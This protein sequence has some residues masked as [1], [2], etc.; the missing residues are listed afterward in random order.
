MT[1]LLPLFLLILTLYTAQK[2]NSQT[3]TVL[4][5]NIRYDNPKD[6]SNRWIF[7]RESAVNLINHYSPQVFGIQ[8]GLYNQN[9]YLKNSLKTYS[10]VGVGREDGK[11]KGEYAA[12][13]YDS[14]KFKLLKS[15]VFWLS[16][17]PDTVSIGWDA[18]L[19]RICTYCLL[20]NQ[21]TNKPFWVFNTH[22]DHIGVVARKM[23]ATLILKKIKEINTKKLPVI[24]M[25]DF[26]SETESEPIN[27]LKSGLLE[28]ST[29]S[30]K[31]LYGPIGT[32]NN[33]NPTNS[34]NNCIDF[35]FVSQFTVASCTHIDDKKNDNLCISDHYPVLVELNFEK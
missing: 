33:F 11:R 26:N 21:A 5:F 30:Q 15:S 1:K 22:F 16:E 12:I 13:F 25:G 31:P 27:L 2:V 34:T 23:S 20:Q 7:R 17:K 6:S 18:A 3:L 24:L 28:T 4:T 29:I 10:Y 19:E 32:F 9:Q 35:I 8:E 14:T